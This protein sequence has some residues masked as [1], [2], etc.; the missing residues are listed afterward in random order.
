MNTN[1]NKLCFFVCRLWLS[2]AELGV[3]FWLKRRIS[4]VRHNAAFTKHKR[5]F[6]RPVPSWKV[7]PFL[8]ASTRRWELTKRNTE[9]RRAKYWLQLSNGRSRGQCKWRN[10]EKCSFP[11]ENR[12]SILYPDEYNITDEVVVPRKDN[13]LCAYAYFTIHWSQSLQEMS[14]T[15]VANITD[16]PF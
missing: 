8:K 2:A 7:S 13:V 4:F 12:K 6:L 11:E 10:E 1:V 15:A 14:L 16:V 5:A 3:K 9:A